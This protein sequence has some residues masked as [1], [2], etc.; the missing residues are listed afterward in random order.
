MSI[1]E[2]VEYR[3]F[4]KSWAELKGRGEWTRL[5]SHLGISSTMMSQIMNENRELNHELANEVCEYLGF[6]ED[7]TNYFFLLVDLKRAGTE[8]LRA[9]LRKRIKEEQTRASQL[10]KRLNQNRE[11]SDA[12][13]SIFYSDWIYSGI[14][15]LASV[16]EF[17]TVDTIAKRLGLTRQQVQRVIDFLVQSG[18]C[19]LKGSQITIGPNKTHVGSD[20][21]WVSQHHRNWRVKAMS[22]MRHRPEENLFY[23]G[24]MSLSQES[25][26][27]IRRR[28][29][30][31]LED[32]YKIVGPSESE[33][34]R[35]LNIDWFE[36]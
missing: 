9:R 20:S 14:R 29:P 12:T 26:R 15:N 6:S 3:Q 18:L 36:Y 23:T 22:E 17:S 34:V 33:T 24:P 16:G 4:L 31:F 25:A 30:T 13:K 1:F 21:P 11:L 5:A 10:S 19:E 28:I 35:C 32:V 8:R 2:T 7:E 27:E